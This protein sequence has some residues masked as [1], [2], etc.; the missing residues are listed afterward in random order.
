MARVPRKVLIDETQVGV[1]HCIQRSVRRAFY[2]VS[3]APRVTTTTTAKAGFD[4]GW[5]IWLANLAWKF[6]PM[7]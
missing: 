6:V 2:V 7:P 5:N 3:I 1:Y 4:G